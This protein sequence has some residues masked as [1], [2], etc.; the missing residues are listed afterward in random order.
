MENSHYEIPLEI[1]ADANIVAHLKGDNIC[2][3]AELATHIAENNTDVKFFR[4]TRS[5]DML[6]TKTHDNHCV[7]FKYH[8]QGPGMK[9]NDLGRTF[10]LYVTPIKPNDKNCMY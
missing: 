1:N 5:D 3:C 7:A 9:E 4:W 8:T 10:R 2:A 6:R